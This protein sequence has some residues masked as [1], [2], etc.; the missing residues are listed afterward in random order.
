MKQK[1]YNNEREILADIYAVQ[2]QQAE[3]LRKAEAHD[4]A[5]IRLSK[6]SLV[7]SLSE[8]ET[9]ELRWQKFLTGKTRRSA[10]RL[11]IKI[12]K[13]RLA[14]DALGT[15]TLDFMKDKSVVL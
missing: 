4:A 7:R 5:S 12:A 9:E 3:L 1:R 8:D 14:Q 10:E 13:L 6:E 2:R 11:D 15:G